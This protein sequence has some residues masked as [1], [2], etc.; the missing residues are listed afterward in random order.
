[1]EA[2]CPMADC[3]IVSPGADEICVNQLRTVRFATLPS[4]LLLIWLPVTIELVQM[5]VAFKP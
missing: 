3:C 5:P 2:A 1:M 4:G